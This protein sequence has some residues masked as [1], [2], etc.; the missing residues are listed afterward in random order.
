M[1]EFFKREVFR[2]FATVFVPGG[3]AILP[4]AVQLLFTFPDLSAFAQAN[5]GA[6][7]VIFL[8]FAIAAGLVTEDIGARIET[9]WDR[10]LNRGKKGERQA[11][12]HL[13]TWERY[14]QLTF[15]EDPI[16][17]NYLRS[18]LVRLKF[19]LGIIVAIPVGWAGFLWLHL[20]IELWSWRSFVIGSLIAL[21]LFLYLIYESYGSTVTLGR[22]RAILVAH[23][24]ESKSHETPP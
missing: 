18:V 14:L 11:G 22:I 1:G 2:P 5:A 10:R 20:T 24:A 23:Y 13:D 12:E 7:V 4:Y 8:M 6:S 21:V 9:C 3:I 19:E 16:G 15:D 17:Q